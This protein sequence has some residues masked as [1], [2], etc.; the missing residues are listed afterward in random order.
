[1][2]LHFQRRPVVASLLAL[3]IGS[4]VTALAWPAARRKI[5]NDPGKL[6][7]RCAP[8]GGDYESLVRVL[9]QRRPA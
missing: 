8:P 9:A 4:V 6:A 5:V 7:H 3:A 2:Q 1:M